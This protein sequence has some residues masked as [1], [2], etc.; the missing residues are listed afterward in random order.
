[1][2]PDVDTPVVLELGKVARRLKFTF[3]AL[4]EAEKLLGK[5]LLDGQ[6]WREIGYR[7]IPVLLSCALKHESPEMTVDKV[8]SLL[9]PEKISEYLTK[10]SEAWRVAQPKAE[11]AEQAD[12]PRS[13]E[14]SPA[15]ANSGQ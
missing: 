10:I 9:V 13:P 11:A 12:P 8:A 4:M 14:S 3:A 5:S 7:D 1:M 6:V 2:A 15:G